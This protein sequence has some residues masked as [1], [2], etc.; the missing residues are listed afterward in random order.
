[1]SEN[2]ADKEVDD[3][4]GVET[5]GHEWDGIKELNNPLPRWWLIVFYICVIWSVGY[6][7]LMPA[8][9]GITGYTKGLRNHSEREN[10][11]TQIA[12]LDA[13]RAEATRRL[14]A[15]PSMEAIEADPELSQFAMAAGQSL[16]GDNCATCHGAGGQGFKGYP[17][18]NDDAWIWGGSLEEIKNTITVGRR[19]T[20]PETPN[21]LMMAYGRDGLLSRE[22][23]SDLTDYVLAISGQPHDEAAAARAAPEF[24]AHA[25]HATAQMEP[26]TNCRARRTSPMR[27][28]FLAAITRRSMRQSGTAAPASCPPGKHAFRKKRSSLFLFMCTHSAAA[29]KRWTKRP[30]RSPDTSL[31]VLK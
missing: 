9:P 13:D 26:A 31:S 2:G 8:W 14:I 19:S 29:S 15:A 4:S 30:R 3:H 24:A 7:V 10:V 20:H 22:Q 16:F 1:M 18:L 11:T 21:T 5:T 17:N 28:G 23:I 27:S 12:A 6:W 25:Q